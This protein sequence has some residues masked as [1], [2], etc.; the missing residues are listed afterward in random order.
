MLFKKTHTI[1]FVIISLIF[2]LSCSSG[3]D[4]GEV[5]I[6]FNNELEIKVIRKLLL[7]QEAS[8][9]L[10]PGY[11]T[12]K[13]KPI[14]LVFLDE[15]GE[16]TVGYLLNI[17]DSPPVGSTKVNTERLNGEVIYRNDDLV[18]KAKDD[19]GGTIP[20]FAFNFNVDQTGF[21]LAKNNISITNP[22]FGFK[23]FDD[24]NVA[25]L[26][27]HELFHEFQLF[28]ENWDLSEIHQDYYGYPQTKEMIALSLL[29]FDLGK[30]AYNS[31]DPDNFLQNYVSVRKKQI[32]L[33]PSEDQLVRFQGIAGE[34]LEGAARY[35]E[36]FGAL[37]TIY[38]TINSDPTHSFKA[39]LD[40]VSTEPL[41]RQIL[42]QRLPYHVGAIVIKI[43]MDKGVDVPAALKMGKTPFELAEM[44]LG[45]SDEAYGQILEQLKLS[46]DWNSYENRAME[47]SQVLN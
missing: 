27:V 12:P 47:L 39:Q 19:F 46:V 3:D 38:P 15:T 16:E 42:V 34:A 28:D 1:K 8:S 23:S 30:E 43:L 22:Y 11:V 31:G 6:D 24:N 36:H 13:T 26:I 37:N 4:V 20:P 18:K 32:E 25:L 9:K 33:D 44:E 17:N 41:A 21:F 10:W 45:K 29:L 40:T 2:A 7:L 14:F 5:G 35:V